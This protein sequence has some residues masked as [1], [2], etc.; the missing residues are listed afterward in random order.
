[1]VV[2]MGRPTKHDERS[3]DA[4]LD[5]AETLLAAGGPESVTVRAVAAE[6]GESTRVVY[7]Q[8]ASMAA[9]MGSL[10]ARGFQMVADLVNQVPTTDDP[11]DDL[12]EVGAGAFRRFA[13]EYPHLFRITFHQVSSEITHQPDARVALQA[14]YTALA[15]RFE[16]AV[17]QGAL[18]P[19]PVIEYAFAFH[20]FTSGLAANELSM[21]PPPVGA[22]FWAL[23]HDVDMSTLWRSAIGSFVRGLADSG[24]TGVS[25]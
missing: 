4:V 19:R 3:R 2:N 11:L 5:A 22:G 23:A 7:S 12:V 15:A 6:V 10:G 20:S 18:P 8:F 13:I 16:H 25:G 17:E 1:M 21:R 24:T 9:L 14:A